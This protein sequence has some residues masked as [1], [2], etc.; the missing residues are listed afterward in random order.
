M[1]V[2]FALTCIIT[3]FFSNT[4][5]GLI[6]TSIS[7]PFVIR[8]IADLG[9]N[10]SVVTAA[11]ATAAMMA[12]LTMAA[13]GTAPLL[14]TQEAIEQDPKFIWTE[15]VGLLFIFIVLGSVV[16]SVMAFVI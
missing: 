14:H 7:A 13:S 5:I 2:V 12:Y 8:Y 15:G 4:A 10:G 9:I 3:N 16:F 11:I 6:M 1:T